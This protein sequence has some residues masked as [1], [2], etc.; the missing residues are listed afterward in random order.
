VNGECEQRRKTKKEKREGRVE[1]AEEG[2]RGPTIHTH[3]LEMP[4]AATARSLNTQNTDQKHVRTHE[5]T[6]RAEAIRYH[7]VSWCLEE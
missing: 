2:D 3:T 7:F 6:R 1:N 4:N 5:S